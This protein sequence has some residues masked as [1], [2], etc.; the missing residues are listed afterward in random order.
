MST[1]GESTEAPEASEAPRSAPPASREQPPTSFG[2][3]GFVRPLAVFGVLAML[4]GRAFGPS[5]RGLAVGLGRTGD[6]LELAGAAMSQFFLIL[7]TVGAM[8]LGLSALRAGLPAV[9]RF[10]A[11]FASGLV[12][13]VTLSA[14]ASRVPEASLV[15][16]GGV[17]CV[18]ALLAAWDTM[19][20]PFARATAVMLGLLGLGGLSRVASVLIVMRD[21]V[22]P[23]AL[24]RIARGVSTVGLLLDGAAMAVAVGFVASRGKKLTSPATVAA[25]AV[26]LFAT[27]QALAGTSDEAAAVSVL[28]ARA[29]K[30]LVL[31]PEPFASPVI[32][33]FVAFAAP[34]IAV[35]ALAT[36]TLTPALSGAIA[37]LLVA[38]GAP[39][40]PLCALALVLASLAT[41]LA[42]RDHRGLWAAIS[43]AES[44]P[45]EGPGTGEAK[46]ARPG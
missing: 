2:V 33:T 38:R 43:R 40:V 27:R 21:G 24:A 30:N 5:V 1:E 31:R 9:V 36:R 6:Y 34:A 35:A 18:L 13:L 7:A 17:A 19:R 28:L 4:L 15:L 12:V 20:T 26:A 29:A 23:E 10:G 16:V 25:L 14:S 46:G 39:D 8:A 42:S 37:L 45:G 32:A 22:A 3:L 11:V 41:V 44:T